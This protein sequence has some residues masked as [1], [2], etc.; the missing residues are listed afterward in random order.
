[1]PPH[2][3]TNLQ[4][5]IFAEWGLDQGEYRR[6]VLRVNPVGRRA[7]AGSD[8]TRPIA[9]YPGPSLGGSMKDATRRAASEALAQTMAVTAMLVIASVILYWR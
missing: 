4:L 9:G 1:M 2:C 7:F 3:S 5:S 6:G 8:E